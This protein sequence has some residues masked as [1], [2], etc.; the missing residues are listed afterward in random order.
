[1]ITVTN[2]EAWTILCDHKVKRAEGWAS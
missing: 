1:V 2:M